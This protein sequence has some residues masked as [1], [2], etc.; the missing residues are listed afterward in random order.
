MK[1]STKIILPIILISAL[2]ILLNG[3][4][5][6]T[7]PDD[8]PGYTPGTTTISGIIAAPC[9]STS[10]L[11][12]VNGDIAPSDWCLQ[13]EVNWFLQK[14]IEVILTYEGEKV[15]STTTNTEGEYTFANL[16]AGD[17]Y[18]ITAIC[19]DDGGK[20]LV[21]DVVKEVVDG[22]NYD[23]G[24]TDC[25]STA[26]GVLVDA[27]VN[28]GISS[29]YIILEDIQGAAKFESFVKAL[30]E[31][32]ESCGDVTVDDDLLDLGNSVLM[33]ILGENPG[34]TG[35]EVICVF[36][37]PPPGVNYTLTTLANPSE[38]GT[39]SGAGTYAS[40]TVVL[41]TASPAVGWSFTGWSGDLTGAANPDNVTMNSDKSVTATFTQDAYT[42]T[43][44]YEYEG[45]AE[46]APSYIDAAMN[47]G[48]PYSVLSPVITGYTAD[49]L[50]VSG[51][52]PAADVNVTVVY[53]CDPCSG[54]SA[55]GV[56]VVKWYAGSSGN[57]DP[58]LNV[59]G[60]ITGPD[61]A[62]ITDIDIELEL[63]NNGGALKES[64]T[65]HLTSSSNSFTV[66][67][68]VAPAFYNSV[69]NYKLWITVPGCSSVMM[70][71]EGPV[72]EL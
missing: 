28:L 39:V 7:V 51:T 33:E 66:D 59:E 50:N 42:L 53:A 69:D 43:I 71:K 38:G 18:V 4:Q 26:L 54:W 45:G 5:V 14:N 11:T 63:Y 61:C 1:L 15:G 44:D 16:S 47:M 24:I 13:C 2:L 68:D 67:L 64:F 25:E 34:W 49:Q 52:M 8:S 6:A 62:G 55:A 65:D 30:C 3:C 9:C 58:R 72:V 70:I 20:P 31:V 10:S 23:A 56:I 57:S 35:G 60:I 21:K 32:L 27:L 22:E 19:P 17:N 29:E 12:A 41:V 36:N 37:P 40:G 48:D 46:A